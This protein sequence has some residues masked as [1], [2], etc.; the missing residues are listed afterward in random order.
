MVMTNG[1]CGT[2]VTRSAVVLVARIEDDR[3]RQIVCADVAAIRYSIYAVV[4][5]CGLRV[6]RLSDVGLPLAVQEVLFDGLVRD[7][8]WTVDDVGYNFRH[9][10]V[11]SDDVIQVGGGEIE[12]VYEL[13]PKE[14]AKTRLRF[15]SKVI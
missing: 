5:G 15:Q 14:G 4:A 13:T 10:L 11:I 6:A 2:T 8:Q 3:G 9:E 12:L 1:A 7:R